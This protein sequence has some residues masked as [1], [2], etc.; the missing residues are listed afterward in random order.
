M[1]LSDIEKVILLPVTE[2][3]RALHF[4]CVT[5]KDRAY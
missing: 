4:S 5:L 1:K 3:L 2:T